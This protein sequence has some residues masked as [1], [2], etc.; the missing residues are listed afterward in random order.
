MWWFPPNVASYNK[1]VLKSVPKSHKK[2]GVKNSD[3]NK[4][5][6]RKGI[7]ELEVHWK[8]LINIQHWSQKE[9]NGMKRDILLSSIYD[10][11]GFVAPL[12]LKDK[13]LLQLLSR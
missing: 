6:W 1:G 5:T 2:D 3:L 4:A 8:G 13:R 7:R 10:P 9:T 12:I 11:L